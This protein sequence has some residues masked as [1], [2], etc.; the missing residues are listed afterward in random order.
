MRLFV[1]HLCNVDFSY[2]CPKRGLVG[3][4]WLANIE[5]KGALDEQGMVCD[6]GTVKKHMR[7]WL[8]EEI[9]HRLLVPN[10]SA[11][12][13]SENN[14]V[15]VELNDIRCRS[16]ETAIALVDAEQINAES[17]AKWASDRLAGSFGPGVEQVSLS[18]VTETIDGPY[19]HYS[20]G[21]KKHLGNCQR[22][23]H[24]HR[25]KIEIWR[26][27]QL[28]E[29]LMQEWAVK[30]QD[31]YIGTEEDLAQQSTSHY[32]FAYQAQQGPFELDLPKDQCYL[33]NTDTTVE[34]IAQHLWQSIKQQEPNNNIRV[35]AYEGIGK[36]ALVEG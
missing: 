24:G 29:D 3:E 10:A 23:A 1:D 35:K 4:T 34:L 14:L 6:F 21:L 2:L 18:F 15:E 28:A 25:S 20:H 33:I 8:D 32:H 16:P 11:K 36:G 7:Q 30:W 19:Y 13:L 5:L 9:D 26:N 31:I 12:C 27:Q 22:I 17:V